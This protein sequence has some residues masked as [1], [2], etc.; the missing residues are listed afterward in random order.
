[1]KGIIIAGGAGTRLRP[2]TYTR[3]KP[4]IPVV[5]RPFLE[6]QVAL[7]KRHG[8]EEII[9]CTNYMADK[10]AAHFG[11]GARFGVR[12]RYALEETPLGTAGAIRNAQEMVGRSTVVVL[13]GDVLTDFDIASIVQFHRDKCAL[14]TLAL[15]EV[16]SPSPYGVIITD[17]E[18]RV[19]EFREPSEAQKKA[20]AANPNIQHT[21]VDYINAGIYIMEPDALDA[22]PTGRPVSVERETY[23]RF[24]ADG[25]PIYAVALDGYWLDIGRAEQ[26][27]QATAAILSRD[28]SVDVPGEWMPAG[29][30]AQ[31]GADIDPTAHI[32]PTVHIGERAR[33]AEGASVTGRTVIGPRCVIGANATLTDCIL[34]EDVIVS[35]GAKLSGVI[36]DNGSHVGPDAVITVPAVFAAGSVIGKGTRIT[37]GSMD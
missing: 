7:L 4:L 33:I 11:D 24:L 36:L 29:Y 1:M 31:D 32:A 30:W 14:V 25:A 15:K 2:L 12:M 35:E 20:I 13:N 3:P 26:Y 34:E 17:D 37:V 18:G 21:G 9:F 5:N 28:I 8:V 6:Y 27:R 19:Q 23:P 16:A 22:I 10:I